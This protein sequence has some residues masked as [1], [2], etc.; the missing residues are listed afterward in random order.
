M[1][2]GTLIIREAIFDGSFSERFS[3]KERRSWWVGQQ[4]LCLS[5]KIRASVV[6]QIL[7]CLKYN[8]AILSKYLKKVIH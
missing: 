3:R 8:E 6:Q 4:L 2:K 7:K 5:L 1:A